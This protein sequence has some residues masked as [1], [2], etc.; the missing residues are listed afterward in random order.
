MPSPNQISFSSDFQKTID[1]FLTIVV[2]LSNDPEELRAKWK[3]KKSGIYCL[4]INKITKSFL[5]QKMEN[6]EDK[7]SEKIKNNLHKVQLVMSGLEKLGILIDERGNKR[8]AGAKMLHFSLEFP[9]KNSEEIQNWVQDKI[10][11]YKKTKDKEKNDILSNPDPV[12]IVLTPSQD[13]KLNELKRK[14]PYQELIGRID[15]TKN[16]NKHFNIQNKQLNWERPTKIAR[17]KD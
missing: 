11:D 7:Y 17:Q 5:V 2:E 1:E 16:I 9:S 8:G 13:K 4:E 3:I 15:S 14:K 6:I 10:K 12:P